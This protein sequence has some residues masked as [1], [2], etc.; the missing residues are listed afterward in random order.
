MGGS[1]G[2]CSVVK[3][4]HVA[5]SEIQPGKYGILQLLMPVFKRLLLLLSD[6]LAILQPPL[7]S[8]V[9]TA[10]FF[11]PAGIFCLCSTYF[12]L[13]LTSSVLCIRSKTV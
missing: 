5:I 11:A 4:V 9:A 6:L 10:P 7:K 8:E 12:T 2:A 3:R 1:S 13:W